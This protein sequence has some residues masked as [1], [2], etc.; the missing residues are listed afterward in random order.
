MGTTKTLFLETDED[1][2]YWETYH[3]RNYP[4]DDWIKNTDS[5]YIC[6]VSDD[7]EDSG[8]DESRRERLAEAEYEV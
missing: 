4:G 6:A 8:N 5:E 2:G 3:R 7:Q 1:D